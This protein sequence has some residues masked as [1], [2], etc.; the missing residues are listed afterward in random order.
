VSGKPKTAPK[1]EEM[2]DVGMKVSYGL[3]MALTQIPEK[4]HFTVGT[5]YDLVV[6]LSSKG[7]YERVCVS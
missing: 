6:I 2:V 3:E 5:P 4:D 1:E 7:M